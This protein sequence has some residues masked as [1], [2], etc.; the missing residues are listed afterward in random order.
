ME[1]KTLIGEFTYINL[2]LKNS[3]DLALDMPA[4]VSYNL[5]LPVDA[6][7]ELINKMIY[8]QKRLIELWIS[9]KGDGEQSLVNLEIEKGALKVLENYAANLTA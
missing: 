4:I 1:N 9:V 3:V 7:L 8:A 6:R 5:S 2:F